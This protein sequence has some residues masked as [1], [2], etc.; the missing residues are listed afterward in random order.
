MYSWQKEFEYEKIILNADVEDLKA[1][2]KQKSLV[3][4]YSE[5]DI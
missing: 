2:I 1:Q 4:H 3:K 5:E